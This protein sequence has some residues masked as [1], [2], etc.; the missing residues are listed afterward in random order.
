MN[1]HS[2][3]LCFV[4]FRSLDRAIYLILIQLSIVRI[5]TALYTR[6]LCIATLKLRDLDR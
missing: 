3:A 4:A 5:L 1:L 2:W 6:C